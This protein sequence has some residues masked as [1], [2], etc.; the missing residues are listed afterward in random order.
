MIKSSKESAH[1]RFSFFGEFNLS[2]KLITNHGFLFSTVFIGTQMA[3]GGAQKVL[4]DQACWFH[5]RGHKVAVVFFYDK[6]NLHEKWQ[7]NVEF[8]ILVMT[9]Y[10]KGLGNVL[11]NLRSS[12]FTNDYDFSAATLILVPIVSTLLASAVPEITLF[13]DIN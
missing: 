8:P 7:A 10:K 6:E 1:S 9:S 3:T 5:A 13:S 4:L 11:I 12:A 2:T